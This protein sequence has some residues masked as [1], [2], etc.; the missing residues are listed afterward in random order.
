MLYR[1][2]WLLVLLATTIPAGAQQGST[3][4]DLGHTEV[5][6][7]WQDFKR[8]IEAAQPVPT[9]A[10]APPREAFLRAA[11]YTGRLDRGVLTLDAVLRMEVLKD[12]WVRL[13]LW[14]QGSVVRFAGGGAVLSRDGGRLEVLASGPRSYQ[15][16]ARHRSRPA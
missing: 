4:P 16:E 14:P 5:T 2:F 1:T 8:L 15:L 9:P 13:P 6:L 10:P 7:S 3:L 11:E 12:A